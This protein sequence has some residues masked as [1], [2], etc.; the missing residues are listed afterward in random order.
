MGLGVGTG[1]TVGAG[2]GV[3]FGVGVGFG[4]ET[5]VGVGNGF[6][7]NRTETVFDGLDNKTPPALTVFTKYR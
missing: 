5:G 3:A 7:D 1:V 4:V 2:V 6:P